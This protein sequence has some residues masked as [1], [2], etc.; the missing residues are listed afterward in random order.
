[1]WRLF[2]RKTF[3]RFDDV[4]AR[5]RRPANQRG[6]F[7][8][9]R[10]ASA[11]KGLT[12]L[13]LI[14]AITIL[15]VLSTAAIPIFRNTIIRS[16][17]SELRRD[18]REMRKAIDRYKDM[19]DRN[20]VGSEFGSQGYPKDL[21]TLVK[22]VPGSTPDSPRT[23]FLRRIPVDPITG[24]AEWDMQ[25]IDDDPDSQSFGGHGVFDVHSKSQ[26]MA[27]DGTSY[28]KW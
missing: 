5:L 3:Q 8:Q 20:L 4:K 28:S 24:K 25:S 22:G 12:L 19:A 15:L 26:A 14:M 11:Q 27:L 18:L 16:K 6:G 13:E 23:R 1:M 2:Q 21:D 7:P 9:S 10:A 17:E